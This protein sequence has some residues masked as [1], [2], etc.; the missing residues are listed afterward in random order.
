MKKSLIALSVLAATSAFAGGTGGIQGGIDFGT[1]VSL[2]DNGVGDLLLAPVFLASGGWQ[3]EI[4]LINT[5]TTLSTVAKVVFYENFRSTEVLDFFV[6][7]SPGDYWNGVI[8][9]QPSG[10]ITV[11]RKSVV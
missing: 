11:D 7:L 9:T 3:S 1:P 5:S 4:K 6:Y 10:Q 8:A 2:A